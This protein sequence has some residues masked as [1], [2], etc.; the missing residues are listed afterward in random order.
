MLW[1]KQLRLLRSA[2]Y[3]I[4]LVEQGIAQCSKLGHPPVT[5]PEWKGI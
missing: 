1:I 3:T 4:L 5:P 2:G